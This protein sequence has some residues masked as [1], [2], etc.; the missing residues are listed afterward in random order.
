MIPTVSIIVPIYNKEKY[1]KKCIDSLVNQTLSDIE[2]VLVDDGSMDNSL[3]ICAEY[4]KIY[5]NIKC[6]SKDNGGVS[7][8]RNLGLD[9][10]TGRF[11]TF[12][13]PDDTLECD[14]LEYL[15]HLIQVYNADVV[16]YKMNMYKNGIIDESPIE[17]ENIEI[18]KDIDI[19]KEYV[20]SGKFLHAVWN[21][22]FR[23]QVI[24]E[25]NIK[26][27]EDIHYAEDALFNYS[28]L[29]KSKTLVFSNSRKYNYFIEPSSTVSNITEKRIDILKAQIRMYELIVREIPDY[30][31]Y[32][33]TQYINSSILIVLDIVRENKV[34]QKKGII[35][36]LRKELRQNLDI[37]SG[38]DYNLLSKSNRLYFRLL[39]IDPLLLAIIYQIK[40]LFLEFKRHEER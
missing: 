26:F 18:Y 7:S 28:V 29:S 9:N 6:L 31:K 17:D 34:Y 30:V 15:Y 1:L 4:Q 37:L 13:D 3:K 27:V 40:V 25:N 22:L 2:I 19:L 12:V 10:C 35:D 14:A 8:A 39:R 32:I 38:Y 33:T 5:P 11:V 20:A 36:E 24:I 23:M 16:G 21:K